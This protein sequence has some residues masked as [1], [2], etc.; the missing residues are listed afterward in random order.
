MRIGDDR[1]ITPICHPRPDRGSRT[2][3]NNTLSTKWIPAFAGMT[4]GLASHA[5]HK[6]GF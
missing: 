3:L 1:S 4:D 6:R 5:K 2:E